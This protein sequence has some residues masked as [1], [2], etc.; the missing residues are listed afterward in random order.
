MSGSRDELSEVRQALLGLTTEMT[1]ALNKS[2]KNIDALLNQMS[3]F[4]QR[5][6]ELSM[7]GV[8]NSVDVALKQKL[9]AA[10]DETIKNTNHVNYELKKA[11]IEKLGKVVNDVDT[12]VKKPG[13]R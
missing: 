13:R 8:S 4:Q 6:A 3:H 9:A 10:L 7:L 1:N 11:Q 5:L 12:E 2:H